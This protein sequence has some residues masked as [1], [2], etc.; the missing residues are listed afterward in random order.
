MPIELLLSFL[1]C[2]INLGCS[3]YY[4]SRTNDEDR[5]RKSDSQIYYLIHKVSITDVWISDSG[6]DSKEIIKN[7]HGTSPFGVYKLVGVIN[8]INYKYRSATLDKDYE[9]ST[10]PVSSGFPNNCILSTDSVGEN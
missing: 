6:I 2:K 5:D 7:R 3:L 10:R 1:D 9:Q 4:N 8:K